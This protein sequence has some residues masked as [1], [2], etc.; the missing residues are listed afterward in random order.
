MSDSTDR[1]TP[2]P[3]DTEPA[4]D[5]TRILVKP[6][7]RDQ[8]PV[9]PLDSEDATQVNAALDDKTRIVSKQLASKPASEAL[10][11]DD[12]TAIHT[13]SAP[14]PS[15][16]RPVPAQQS[17]ANLTAG[18]V[19]KERFKLL[20]LL[21]E[22]GMGRVFL[23]EDQIK[24]EAKSTEPNIAIKVLTDEFKSHPTSFMA[25]QREVEKSQQ[26]AHPNI[27]TAFDFDRDHD[28]IYMTMEFLE[29]QDLDDY[30]RD[31]KFSGVE[32][33]LAASIILQL[34]SG[35]AHAHKK[36]L[37]HSDLKPANVFL[38][39]D[40]TVKILDFG[41]ARVAK[42]LNP[43]KAQDTFDVGVLGALTPNYASCD[44]LD[45]DHK[46]TPG[47]DIYA[48]GVIAYQLF[49]GNH[50]FDRTPANE[51]RDKGMK[52]RRL[53]KA[54][55]HQ[56]RAI[57]KALSF[58]QSEG[59][60]NLEEF[61]QLFKG[62]SKLKRALA[63][64]AMIMA[65]GFSYSYYQIEH[66]QSPNI[67]FEDLPKAQQILVK[68]H[69]A[70]A[71]IAIKFNDLNGAIIHLNEAFN[72]HPYNYEVMERIDSTVDAIVNF[73]PAAD[74]QGDIDNYYD[75]LSQLQKYKALS[76]HKILNRHLS[77]WNKSS[78]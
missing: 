78:K 38:T 1:P 69:I 57:K 48:L 58:D 65:V 39:A 40:N 8:A 34:A 63:A 36:G 74:Q 29:G 68:D 67:D 59:L 66:V 50:P 72:L 42:D 30:I 73:Q 12:A 62:P 37:I 45:G 5:A 76:N 11:D 27:I 13:V 26:I 52:P 32:P 14:Q 10:S 71:D 44:M 56:W 24:V 41:I 28:L 21:G 75:N 43:L 47:D 54:S 70:Q 55:R 49:S 3:Q 2:E 51:A 23:A 17:V 20:K 60:K 6:A 7:D 9:P 25:L 18:S 61:F 33:K 16:I 77:D 64:S 35:L 15:V 22:G 19:I 53:D 4:S 46:P 31:H